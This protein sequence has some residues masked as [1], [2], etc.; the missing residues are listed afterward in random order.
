MWVP[1]RRPGR[2]GDRDL[3]TLVAVTRPQAGLKTVLKTLVTVTRPQA[4]LLLTSLQ[5]RG[6][7][8]RRGRQ[9]EQGQLHCDLMRIFVF[10]YIEKITKVE[11]IQF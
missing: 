11:S 7:H 2:A 9:Y 6:R 1:L 10:E 5:A 8:H 3:K 4:G